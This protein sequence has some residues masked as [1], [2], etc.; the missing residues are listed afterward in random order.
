MDDD[1]A[2]R[3]QRFPLL[4][5]LDEDGIEFTHFFNRMGH[6][7]LP[8]H[9]PDPLH[10]RVLQLI[11]R[12]MA[13]QIQALQ[14]IPDELPRYKI[15]GTWA[16]LPASLTPETEDTLLLTAWWMELER[17]KTTRHDDWECQECGKLVTRKRGICQNHECVS[18]DILH[19]ITGDPHL[20]LVPKTGTDND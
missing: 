11:E 10:K 20:H 15:N 2:R 19:I 7:R 6:V 1:S 9:L 3:A 12:L 16:P 5:K 4:I 18:W 8:P 13:L 17:R 14:L